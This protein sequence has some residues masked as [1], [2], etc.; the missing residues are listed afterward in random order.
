[1]E[2]DQ[3]QSPGLQRIQEAQQAAVA[4]KAQA[5]QQTRETAIAAQKATQEAKRRWSETIERTARIEQVLP[6]LEEIRDFANRTGTYPLAATDRTETYPR[7]HEFSLVK[8][9]GL[10]KIIEKATITLNKNSFSVKRP[11][12]VEII[13]LKYSFHGVVPSGHSRGHGDDVYFVSDNQDVTIEQGIRL[14]VYRP[15]GLVGLCRQKAEKEPEWHSS[16]WGTLG[17]H[18]IIEET[19]EMLPNDEISLKRI[20]SEAFHDPIYLGTEP[21]P[22]HQEEIT[23]PEPQAST[24]IL[25]LVKGFLGLK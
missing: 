12:N 21:F 11:D 1:M 2:R 4:A 19:C 23:Q 3:S 10:P 8:K 16:K 17:G 9:E 14:K 18:T 20:L 6:L 15:S 22:F 5:E 25:D 24:G 7:G 13:D